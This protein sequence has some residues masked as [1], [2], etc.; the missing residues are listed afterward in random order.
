[1]DWLVFFHV[2]AM[3]IAVAM[4][5]GTGIFIAS[6]SRSADPVAIRVAIPVARRLNMIGG[7]S[8]L[9]G[10]VLGFAVA[11]N[12]GFSLTSTWL[13]VTYVCIAIMIVLV[14]GVLAPWERR[15]DAAA[16]E[17][18]SQATPAFTAVIGNPAPRIAGPLMGL[19]WMVV[20]A[21]MVLRPQ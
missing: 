9:V 11:G 1:M 20:I 18:G 2:L 7:I 6:I 8:L 19:L 16:K 17:A 3:F 21:M 15:V 5:A 13:V 4:S 10:L 14:A 12:A